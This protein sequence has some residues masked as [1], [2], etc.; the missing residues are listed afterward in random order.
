MVVEWKNWKNHTKTHLRIR[1]VWILIRFSMMRSSFRLPISANG[2]AISPPSSSI[3]IFKFVF[4]FFSFSRKFYVLP[5][6]SLFHRS[7]FR[8]SFTFYS[9]YI[10]FSRG[11][12]F[13]HRCGSYQNS[14]LFV[15]VLCICMW[16]M[17]NEGRA[18]CIYFNIQTGPLLRIYLMPMVPLL[19]L[20]IIIMASISSSTL[21]EWRKMVRVTG[22]IGMDERWDEDKSNV[23]TWENRF[24]FLCKYCWFLYLIFGYLSRDQMLMHAYTTKYG[25]K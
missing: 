14:F 13:F 20:Y 24:S 15:C 6:P 12:L 25:I 17:K 1:I 10:L 11:M 9:I 19:I 7:C 23:E 5:S 18:W 4:T 16:R 22:M 8:C 2:T 3:A 21:L